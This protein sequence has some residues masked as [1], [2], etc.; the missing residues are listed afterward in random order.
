MA[1]HGRQPCD[2][3]LKKGANAAKGQGDWAVP[4]ASG[5]ADVKC[6]EKT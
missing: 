1:Y 4:V 3:R 2:N 6:H 5:P